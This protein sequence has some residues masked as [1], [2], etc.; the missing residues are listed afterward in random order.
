[1]ERIA[2]LGG[3]ERERAILREVASGNV[4]SFLRGLKPVELDHT[5]RDGKRVRV[6]VWV[7]PDYLSVGSD[8]DYVR[9]PIG[10]PTAIAIARELD[11]IL[12]TRKIVD[13]VHRQSEL[14]LRPEPMKPGPR[15]TG[16]EYFREHNG[17][18][19]RQLAGR[20]PG[21]LVSGHKK[22]LV[23]TNRLARAARRVAIYGWHRRSGE[24]IQPL[25]TVHG[26]RY[27][28]YS[29]GVRL[30]SATVEVNGQQRSIYDVL[31]QPRLAR[32]LTYE[33]T[34]KNARG[35]MGLDQPDAARPGE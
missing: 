13:A 24:P 32:A 11:C 29:H 6:V 19:E 9:V 31:E 18:I 26:A 27:A 15:M 30:V 25:S 23:I 14:R 34:I 21:A 2:G 16:S 5:D 7:M 1:M 33:G 10:L 17:K 20:E 3:E 4:P 22:D 12:P 28:D 8:D 35:L